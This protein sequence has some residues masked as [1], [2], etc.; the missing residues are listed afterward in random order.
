MSEVLALAILVIF[1]FILICSLILDER[2][3]TKIAKIK[4]YIEQFHLAIISGNNLEDHFNIGPTPSENHPVHL[5]LPHHHGVH[6]HQ[7]VAHDD[8]QVPSAPEIVEDNQDYP[9]QYCELDITDLPS[10][11]Q[12]CKRQ[13]G[14]TIW[15]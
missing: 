8:V 14:P 11:E 15:D 4:E 10:Y 5:E 1:G 7:D 6:H 2:K 12:S 3:K 13:Y 9:P